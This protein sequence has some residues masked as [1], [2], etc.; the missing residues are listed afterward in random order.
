MPVKIKD[1]PGPSA[2][3]SPPKLLRWIAVLVCIVTIGILL[4]RLLGKYIDNDR[5][6]W[7]AIGVPLGGWGIVASFFMSV[8]V[9]RHIRANA[10]DRRREQYI[11]KQVRRGRRALQILSA[12]CITAHTTD[13][14][15]TTIAE[16]LQRNLNV[17]FPQTSWGGGDN[18]RHSRLP[19]AEGIPIAS[20]V[21]TAFSALLQKISVSLLTL[22]ADNPVAILLE[23]SSSLPE[24]EIKTIWLQVWQKYGMEQPIEFVSGQGLEAVDRWLDYRINENTVLLVIALQIA[25]EEPDMTAEA[26]VGLLLGNQLTQKTLI[27]YALLHRPEASAMNANALQEGVLQAADWVPL[28]PNAIEHLW[29]SGINETSDARTSVF[30]V[31]GKPPLDHISQ[32][33]GLHDFNRYLGYPG[34]TAPWLA[35]TAAAQL[36]RNTPAAHMIIS[37]EQ[38]SDVVWSTVISPHA[39]LPQGE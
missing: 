17:L 23:S 29:L 27:P 9:L 32:N 2:R 20:V 35:I 3:P 8:F 12:E 37:G 33:V 25:P 24:A 26:V 16:S 30:V 31:Q 28:S 21:V 11:L 18:I 13:L 14:R 5:F 7:L 1:I 39:S 22:P 34:C 4:M 19:A 36:I 38:N 15:L 10:Y 6:W